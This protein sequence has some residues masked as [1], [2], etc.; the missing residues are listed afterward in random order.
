[1]LEVFDAPDASL[2]TGARDATSSTVQS[3]YLMNNDFVQARAEA[4]SRRVL[5]RPASQRLDD[6]FMLTL[7]RPPT[8][9]ERN[10]A[11][12]FITEVDATSSLTKDEKLTAVCQ[13]LLSTSEF[14]SID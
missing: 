4:L 7:G 5:E 2:V 3:L 10:L 8:D 11:V 1:M 13:A 14:S 6:T 9:S 12:K